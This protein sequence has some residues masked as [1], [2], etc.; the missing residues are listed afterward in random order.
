[1]ILDAALF[2]PRPESTCSNAPAPTDLDPI[3]SSIFSPCFCIS[4]S[5]LL[6]ILCHESEAHP[7]TSQRHP[8]SFAKTPGW[9]QERFLPLARQSRFTANFFGRNTYSRSPCFAVF[10][11]KSSAR[12]PI[13]INT[14]RNSCCN[15]FRSNTYRNGGRGDGS[16][17]RSL[18]TSFTSRHCA[19]LISLCPPL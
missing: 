9:H 8:H 15:S 12:K 5:S 16:P 4:L 1:M 11:P 17:S 2:S 3:L 19:R 13:R 6:C 14:Y 7:L 18:P 10:W